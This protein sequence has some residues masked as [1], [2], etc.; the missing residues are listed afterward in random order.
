MRSRSVLFNDF[1][2]TTT[3]KYTVPA[4]TQA[5]WVLA[6]VHNSS[7]STVANVGVDILY[8]AVTIPI[9]GTKSFTSSESLKFG[10]GDYVILEAGAEIK[11]VADTT[12][13]SAVFTIEETNQLVT[14]Y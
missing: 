9:I 8:N 7:G 14:T 11:V 2:A 1:P 13:I 3:T 10:D 5:K 6:Y 12:G 4:N